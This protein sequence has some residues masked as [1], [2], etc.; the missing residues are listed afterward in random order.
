M[1]ESQAIKDLLQR[2]IPNRQDFFVFEY[3]DADNGKDVYEIDFIDGKIVLRGNNNSSIA[4][5]LGQYLKY[6]ANVNF[7]WCGCD[8]ALSEK[9]PVPTFT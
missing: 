9:L 6:T 4:F 8:T 2:V 1:R 7:S 5:A 3:I